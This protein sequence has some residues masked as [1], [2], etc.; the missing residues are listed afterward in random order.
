MP[1]GVCP[2]FQHCAPG[3]VI[4]PETC[5]YLKQWWE[6]SSLEPGPLPPGLGGAGGLGGEGMGLA[7]GGGGGKGV[8]ASLSAD[9]EEGGEGGG[10]AM[11]L[12]W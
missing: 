6:D 10:S 11:A 4:S 9:G 1:C 2:V 5:E 12:D 8:L 7:A 3:A